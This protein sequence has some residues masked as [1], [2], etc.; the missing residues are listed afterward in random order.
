MSELALFKAHCGMPWLPYDY[1]PVPAPPC[2]K[3]LTTCITPATAVQGIVSPKSLPVSKL[4]V[5]T[6]KTPQSIN[7][8]K[9]AVAASKTPA[10][11]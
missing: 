7:N 2:S 3:A 1:L 9:Y 5:R 4:H 10:K 8:T 11:P 6:E